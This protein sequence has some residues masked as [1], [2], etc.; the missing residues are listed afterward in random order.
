MME[1]IDIFIAVVE[2]APEYFYYVPI[3]LFITYVVIF[4]VVFYAVEMIL[5][6]VINKLLAHKEMK[7]SRPYSGGKKILVVGDSTAVGTGAKGRE[8]TIAGRFSKDFPQSDILNLAINGSLTRDVLKQLKEAGNTV[9]DLIIIST[10][11]NDIWSF[12]SLSSLSKSLTETLRLANSMS[13]HKVI[14]LFF[15]NEGSAPVFP[16]FIRRLLLRRTERVKE[17]FTMITNREK[18]PCIELFTSYED[19]PFIRD[20]KRFFARDGLHP[21]GEGYRVWYERMWR[22]M[23]ENGYFYDEKHITHTSQFSGEVHK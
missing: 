16:F 2:R 22:V 5:V 20:P 15:G 4:I 8:E 10:G 12:T 11:G 1:I 7:F 6:L 18:V 19:N 9:F 17:I 13:N 3:S 21:S 23:V 14:V